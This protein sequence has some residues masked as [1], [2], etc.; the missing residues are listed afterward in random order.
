[1]KNSQSSK[2]K[3][4]AIPERF[5]MQN[6]LRACNKHEN[7][8]HL[9]TDLKLLPMLQP[10]SATERR[11]IHKLSMFDKDTNCVFFTLDN[12]LNI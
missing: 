1:M 9:N 5:D 11:Y 2:S 8:F 6:I 4:R 3:A 7:K 10:Y 12:F